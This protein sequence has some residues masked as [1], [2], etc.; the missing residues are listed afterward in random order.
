MGAL[1]SWALRKGWLFLEADSEPSKDC[2]MEAGSLL[3]KRA[4][5]LLILAASTTAPL[6]PP[7]MVSIHRPRSLPQQC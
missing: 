4:G 1:A 7:G 6:P 2:A 3:R 5:S